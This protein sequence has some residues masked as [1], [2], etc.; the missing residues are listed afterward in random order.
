MSIAV[1][2]A[3]RDTGRSSTPRLIV[4]IP[5]FNEE[6]FIGSVVLQAR[7]QADAVI[8]VDDG[9]ND[10]TA[11]IARLAEGLVLRHERNLGKGVALNT[12]FRHARALGAD[13]VVILDADGQHSPEDLQ[14]VVAPILDGRAD[15][16]VGSRYLER[17]SNV[18]APRVLGHRI[19]NYLTH[20]ASGV[21]L[22]DSQS[23]FRAF[24]RRA[25]Q[26]LSFCSPGFSVE[27][28]MQFIARDHSLR[29]VE[30]PIRVTYLDKPKRPVLKH[31][32][33]VLNGVLRL[34]GQ[35]RPLLFFGLPGFILI[36][37]GFG[38]GV[39]VVE[40][41][42]A[43]RLLAVGYA[44]ISIALTLLGTVALFSGILLHSIRGLLLSLVGPARG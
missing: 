41:Y 13:A 11:E 28:E 26:V 7:R 30:V 12:G 40:I 17:R 31:G 3:S 38:W 2:A 43:S 16:V 6:R 1:D 15:I 21:D 27:S 8:V 33:L 5:A 24:S 39:W 18:P 25:L 35:Y 23:G 20:R 10:A 29:T 14:R 42:Q 37:V 36:L 4:I 44:L 9:S 32:L 19:F 34:V 22:T